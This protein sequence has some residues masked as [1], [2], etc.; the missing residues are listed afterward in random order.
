MGLLDDMA[1]EQ[2]WK[3]FLAYKVGKGHLTKKETARLA[4][5]IANREYEKLCNRL[6]NGDVTFALPTKKQVNKVNSTKKRTVYIFPEP[7]IWILKLMSHLLY[8]YDALFADNLYS[9]R[10]QYGAKKAIH[11][12]AGTPGI[13]YM[14]GY[15]LDVA[16]YFNSIDILQLLPL[17]QTMMADDR[18]L[19]HFLESLLCEDKVLIDGAV[20]EEKRG[21]M[22]G[23]P[24]APFLANAYLAPVDFMFQN[25]NVVYA[26]YSDDILMFAQTK[27]ERDKCIA[28]LSDA[29]HERNLEVNT[30]KVY[31][32][33]PGDEWEF[34][35]VSYRCKQ[36]DLSDAT[37]QKMKG[38]IKRKARAVY[39]WKVR[40]QVPE[41]LAMKT[42]I[43]VFNNKF[44]HATDA[45]DLTW[46][47]WFF[48]LLTTDASLAEIDAYL[49]QNI[50]YL[51][52][53]R[54]S[55]K[56]FE[57]T[58][59]QMKKCGYRSLVHEYWNGKKLE[60]QNNC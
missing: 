28:Y 36:I 58:Y 29:L 33:N 50:R 49:Q 3:D 13:D 34:L 8:R 43:R 55:K 7:E 35:G 4:A 57:V 37:V 56:N 22:A 60:S 41:D 14:Y 6:V 10:T 46:S 30:S 52:T 18:P 15:K 11:E 1:S 40:K 31:M 32:I 9:F 51:S 19:Y 47:R 27:E 21:V 39:R 38:K 16:N 23:C 24:I 12:M 53:G 54:Y 45:N 25:R 20:T 2:T 42:L 5:F 48:P 44:F 59:D 26:R 17:L